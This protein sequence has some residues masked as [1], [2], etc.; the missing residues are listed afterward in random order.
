[1]EFGRL[2][3]TLKSFRWGIGASV[4]FF[5]A[6]ALAWHFLAA[7]KFTADALVYVDAIGMSPTGQ[8]GG[9]QSLTFSQMEIATSE[10]V[11]VAAASQLSAPVR[12]RLLGEKG[13]GQDQLI[14]IIRRAVRATAG[15]DS[16][17]IQISATAQD[18]EV[19]SELANAV[20]NGYLQVSLALKTEPARQRAA[21]FQARVTELQK[22]A[23]EAQDQVSAF[24]RQS[25]LVATGADRGDAEQ[26]LLGEMIRRTTELRAQYLGSAAAR[27]EAEANPSASADVLNSTVVQG[28]QADIARARSRLK[29]LDSRLGKNHPQYLAATEELAELERNLARQEALAASSVATAR[30][31]DTRS[32]DKLS[33]AVDK[34]KSVIVDLTEKREQLAQLQQR[35]DYARTSFEASRDRLSEALIESKANLGATSIL[36]AAQPP[37]EQSSTPL[38]RSVPLGALLGFMFGGLVAVIAE[39]R[40]PRLRAESDLTRLGLRTIAMIPTAIQSSVQDIQLLAMPAP[41]ASM[42]PH[43]RRLGALLVAAGK[44]SPTDGQTVF[45]EHVKRK[46]PY[47]SAAVRMGLVS[48]SDVLEALSAQYGMR[49]MTNKSVGSH[50]PEQFVVDQHPSHPV[51]EAVR[52]LRSYLMLEAEQSGRG[53]MVAVTSPDRGDG[54][55]FIVANLAIACSQAGMRTLL[56]EADM[57]DPQLAVRFGSSR[58][59]GLSS[60][61]AGLIPKPPIL[62]IDPAG[63][64]SLLPAGPRPPNP[65]ELLSHSRFADLMQDLSTRF[66]L[67]LVDS[68]A[69]ASGSDAQIIAARAGNA[70]IVGNWNETRLD[71]LTLLIKRLADAGV[72]TIGAIV[73]RSAQVEV[74]SRGRGAR[75]SRAFGE[76]K[77]G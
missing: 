25:G 23:V 9:V 8:A 39:H 52:V 70:V 24:R 47:G 71:A 16:T 54:K 76:S 14:P 10:R 67:V 48:E 57:R 11:L 36:A 29:E 63:Y 55:S 12:A 21:F 68:P 44:L 46:V 7:P 59:E 75:R 30:R 35:A 65:Q 45:E 15:R 73:N 69:N 18:A 28:L 49:R 2:F 41:A 77:F 33:Q 20:A 74:K 60:Y 6:A 56:V 38:Q 5:V 32:A 31:G 1:M 37:Q 34:Q 66:D 61:L 64:L 17:V 50:T 42:P 3:S 51:A 22:A 58:R 27:S 72:Q 26:A 4:V 40:R 13:Q 62:P 19:A 53:N 43:E